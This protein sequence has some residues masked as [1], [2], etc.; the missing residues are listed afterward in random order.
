MSCP[1]SNPPPNYAVPYLRRAS[2]IC[3]RKDF[4]KNRRC[5]QGLT[6]NG[7]SDGSTLRWGGA[8]TVVLWHWVHWAWACLGD[9]GSLHL[10]GGVATGATLLGVHGTHRSRGALGTLLHRSGGGSRS[11]LLSIGSAGSDLKRTWRHSLTLHSG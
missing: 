11:K 3:S 1:S 4:L 10:S 5:L 8:G 6:R 9:S 7:F 2:K